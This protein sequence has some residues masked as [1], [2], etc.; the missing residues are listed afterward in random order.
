METPQENL[1]LI[2]RALQEDCPDNDVS[3]D[4]CLS[5]SSQSSAKIIAKEDGVFYGECCYK[6]IIDSV[7]SSLD[8]TMQIKDGETFK[9]GDTLLELSGCTKSILKIER[10]LLTS[11]N[12]YAA[13]VPLLSNM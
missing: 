5:A 1:D 12:I 9:K 10:T 2:K 6:D 11:S 4:L 3:A 13:L 7:D 8:C